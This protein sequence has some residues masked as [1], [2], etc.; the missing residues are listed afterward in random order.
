M[1]ERIPNGVSP[2]V[3]NGKKVHGLPLNLPRIE[4]N[5]AVID[6]ALLDVMGIEDYLSLLKNRT[7]NN[8]K[9][10]WKEMITMAHQLKASRELLSIG[11]SLFS[12]KANRAIMDRLVESA[13]VILNAERVYLMEIDPTGSDLVVTYSKDEKA[14][15]LKTPLRTGIEGNF[16]IGFWAVSFTPHSNNCSFHNFYRRC[17]FEK[18]MRKR[19]RRLPRPPL[20]VR[21]G[22]ETGLEN[23][24]RDLCADHLQRYCG[25]RHPSDQQETVGSNFPSLRAP[26]GLLAANFLL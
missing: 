4:S 21:A 26:T 16:H 3:I 11:S 24:V 10:L 1:A 15:G 23:A 6:A 9:E 7:D 2:P 22:L 18:N 5:E 13:H 8:P 14:I 20:L 25:G 12:N 17:R 19:T